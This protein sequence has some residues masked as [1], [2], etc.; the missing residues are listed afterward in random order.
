MFI[1]QITGRPVSAPDHSLHSLVKELIDEAAPVAIHNRNSVIN[2]IPAGVRIQGNHRTVTT[3][4]S[5]LVNTVVVHT[6]NSGI[7]ISAKVYGFVILVQVRTQGLISP[8]LSNEMENAIQKARHSGGVI[9]LMQHQE[10]QA[11][12]AY[13]F[14]NVSA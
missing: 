13:C 8:D 9:E 1:Q 4:L 7:L 10:N 11:S 3:I 2:E 12:V 14:L 6:R 5:N